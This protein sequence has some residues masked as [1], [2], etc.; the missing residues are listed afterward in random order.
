MPRAAVTDRATGRAQPAK[1]GG[2]TA[3]TLPYVVLRHL[4]LERPILLQQPCN[5]AARDVLHEDG[6]VIRA[7]RSEVL[8]SS[9]ER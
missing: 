8:G 9:N 7:I 5:A 4:V 6:E 2:H 1:A 3:K